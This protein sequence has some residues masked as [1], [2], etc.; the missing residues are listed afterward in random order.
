MSCSCSV[1]ASLE[2]LA[3]AGGE[4]VDDVHLVAARDERVDYVRA[5]E[6][7]SPGDHRPHGRILAARWFVT[8]EGIDGSG[9]TTQA[10]ALRAGSRPRAARS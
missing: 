3:P 8:F 4:V 10:S 6:A 9:K 7:R 5:D 1:A 2:V